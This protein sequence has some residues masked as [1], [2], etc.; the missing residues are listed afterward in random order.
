MALS[1]K[2][3]EDVENIHGHRQDRVYNIGPDRPAIYQ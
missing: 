1:C 3:I 2:I